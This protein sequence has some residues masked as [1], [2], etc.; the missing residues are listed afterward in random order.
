MTDHKSFISKASK[1]IEWYAQLQGKFG[2]YLFL[3]LTLFVA[4]GC[5]ARYFL[6]ITVVGMIEIPSYLFLIGLA[7]SAA[8]A[9]TLGGHIRVTL[10]VDRLSRKVRTVTDLIC[11]ILSLIVCSF[12]CWACIVT[13]LRWL[14]SNNI[15]ADLGLPL[16]P[17]MFILVIG[18]LVLCLELLFELLEFNTKMKERDV[19]GE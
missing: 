5:F 8:Y 19:I 18:F 16:F 3:P 4:W 9:M 15:S 17:L 12:I 10:L 1:V 13:A 6:R 14:K 7:L 2:G 11:L